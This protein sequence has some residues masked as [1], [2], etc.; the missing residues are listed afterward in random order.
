MREK[1]K[2]VTNKQIAH[3]VQRSSIHI[4]QEKIVIKIF[5]KQNI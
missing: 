4:Q 3:K 5:S 1:K 2:I